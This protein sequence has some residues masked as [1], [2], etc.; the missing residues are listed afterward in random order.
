MDKVGAGHSFRAYF[1]VDPY[2]VIMMTMLILRN[3][4]KI[5]EMVWPVRNI[6]SL[7]SWVVETRIRY[8]LQSC[9][10]L[11]WTLSVLLSLFAPPLKS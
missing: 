4:M 2:Q 11:E 6:P 7:S 1:I 3:M 10:I 9:K 8:V 5:D